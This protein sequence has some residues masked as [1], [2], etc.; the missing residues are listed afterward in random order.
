MLLDF[1]NLFDKAVFMP[2]RF[3]SVRGKRESLEFRIEMGS[4]DA[5]VLFC[6]HDDLKLLSMGDL[7]VL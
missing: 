6:A 3:G 5:L 7:V 2:K 4:F 1:F